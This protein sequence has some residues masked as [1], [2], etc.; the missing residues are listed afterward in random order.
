[1]TY[2]AIPHRDHLDVLRDQNVL[3]ASSA[4][5]FSEVVGLLDVLP[6]LLVFLPFPLLLILLHLLEHLVAVAFQH[7]VLHEFD[8]TEQFVYFVHDVHGA[9]PHLVQ[10]DRGI[11]ASARRPRTRCL[12]RAVNRNGY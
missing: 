7:F 10:L 5:D 1:M 2:L 4:T 9:R 11:G 6:D 12:A 3:Q 8:A